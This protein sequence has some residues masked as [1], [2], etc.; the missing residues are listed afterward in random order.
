MTQS[1]MINHFEQIKETVVKLFGDVS[2]EEFNKKPSAKRWSAA[3]CIEHL[4]LSAQSYLSG[5]PK[6]PK[7]SSVVIDDE[8]RIKSGLFARSF[9]HFFGPKIRMKIKT[10]KR[11]MTSNS[12]YSKDIIDDFLS[13]QDEFITAIRCVESGELRSIKAVWPTFEL[14][15]LTLADVAMIT[16]AHELRHVNQAERALDEQ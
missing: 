9:I 7:R 1:E 8:T 3:E 13:L 12:S 15:K 14:K 10:P 11:M 5:V 16:I 6:I 4:N 2:V